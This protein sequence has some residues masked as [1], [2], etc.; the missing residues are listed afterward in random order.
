MT[1]AACCEIGSGYS[2]TGI[3][4]TDI[5]EEA[6]RAHAENPFCDDDLAEVLR[7]RPQIVDG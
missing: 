2:E 1:P 7:A 6:A 3:L 5:L 4:R